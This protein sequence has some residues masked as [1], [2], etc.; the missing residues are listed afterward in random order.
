MKIK[1]IV[2]IAAVLT[3]AAPVAN[4]APDA[5]PMARP[6][7]DGLADMH[8]KSNGFGG[9]KCVNRGEYQAMKRAFA[10]KILPK[11]KRDGYPDRITVNK[12]SE[13]DTVKSGWY[14]R[15]D[16][17]RLPEKYRSSDSRVN[18]AK[19]TYCAYKAL[20]LNIP[21]PEIAKGY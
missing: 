6:S 12:A 10:D 14:V 18:Q 20:G 2:L 19:V 8:C 17:N 11:L 16:C 7:G 9:K 3:C 21:K 1:T 5:V 15:Q 13:W 4:A